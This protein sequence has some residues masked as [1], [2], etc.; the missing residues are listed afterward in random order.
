MGT[1]SELFRDNL[2]GSRDA[3]IVSTPSFDKDDVTE[4]GSTSSGSLRQR[5]K[6]LRD[7]WR[8]DTCIPI[9]VTVSIYPQRCNLISSG[10]NPL[11]SNLA[12]NVPSLALSS[13]CFLLSITRTLPSSQ[14]CGVTVVG[15]I[16]AGSLKTLINSLLWN[17]SSCSHWCWPC[18]MIFSLSTSSEI[19]SGW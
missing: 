11:K 15:S 12:S 14:M 16:P 6:V 8:P 18:T 13:T 1:S 4:L 2:A 17:P 10:L 5:L 9:P 7:C 3:F 19:S